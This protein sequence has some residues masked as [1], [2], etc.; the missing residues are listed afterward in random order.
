MPPR[1]GF[2]RNAT[3]MTVVTFGILAA[4]EGVLHGIGEILQGYVAPSEIF[5][6]AWPGSS[7]TRL[8]GGW[9]AVTIVPNLFVSGILTVLLSLS[10]YALSLFVWATLFTM[11]KYDGP[12]PGVL[13]LISSIALFLVGGGISAPFIGFVVSIAWIVINQPLEWRRTHLA[14]SSRRAKWWP[15]SFISILIFWLSVTIGSVIA[16]ICTGVTPNSAIAALL[17]IIG[18]ALLMLAIFTGFAYDTPQLN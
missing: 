1:E 8:L 4:I 16:G 10:I 18:A 6:Q 2:E 12:F 11:K 13:L 3:R 17:S 7:L 15:W 5:I 9:S 14:F